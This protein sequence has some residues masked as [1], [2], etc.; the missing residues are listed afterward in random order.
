MSR[1][2]G[3][4]VATRELAVRIFLDTSQV[5]GASERASG[6]FTGIGA[7]A[8]RAAVAAQAAM[9]RMA[10][11][12]EGMAGKVTAS[13]EKAAA[14]QIAAAERASLAGVAGQER[15]AAAAAEGSAATTA[16]ADRS[17]ASRIGAAD[18]AAAAEIAAAER[19]AAAQVRAAEQAAAAQ[20]ASRA[21]VE[22]QALTGF[23][24]GTSM[25][26]LGV[27]VAGFAGLASILSQTKEYETT[28]SILRQN[29]QASDA[30]M[31]ALDATALRLGND[32]TIPGA[33][34]ADAARAMTEL[35]K[36][37]LTVEQAMAAAKGTLQL[38]TAA[39][40]DGA[41][42]ADIETSALG[43]FQLR[44]GDAAHVADVLANTAVAAKG[45]ITD[46][47]YGME[48]AGTVAHQFGMSIDDTSTVL[49]LFAKNG[50]IGEQ[51]GT[52]LRTMLVKMAHPTLAA[53]NAMKDLGITVYDAQGKFEGMRAL[54]EQLAAAHSKM[55]LEEFNA[56][57]ATIFGTRAIRG[58][59]IAAAEG[60]AGW[61]SM[62]KKISE[63][64]GVA[65]MAEAHMAG[66][67]GGL[68]DVG[69]SLENMAIK[70][71]QK[72]TPAL[73]AMAHGFAEGM[74]V[75]SAVFTVMASAVGGFLTVL[76]SLPAPVWAAV[77]ALTAIKIL[78]GP[79]LSMFSM[80]APRIAALRETMAAIRMAPL[81]DG[82][83][84]LR[85]GMGVAASAAGNLGRNML[86]LVGGPIGAA[87]IM[88]AAGT[89]IASKAMDQAA[90]STADFTAAI[91]DQTGAL[92]SNAQAMAAKTLA[93]SGS[94]QKAKDM[95]ISADVYTKAV[96]GN[97]DAIAQ[98]NDA[99][100]RG[101]TGQSEFQQ[102]MDAANQSVDGGVIA[103]SK[104]QGQWD[105]AS[106][107]ANQFAA[108]TGQL[109]AQV[110]A[111][112][113]ALQGAGNTTVTT[114]ASMSDLSA[115]L[116]DAAVSADDVASAMTAQS[117]AT[118]AAKEST[119]YLTISMQLMAGK[120]V[121]AEAAARANAAAMRGI[122][123]AA[124]DQVSAN[125]AAQDA[126]K[127]L[128][129]V[130][131]HLHDS[132]EK[133]RTSVDDVTRAQ[134]ALDDANAKVSAG[135]E[136]Q[137]S[138]W[139]QAAQTA[140]TMTDVVYRQARAHM[141]QKDAVAAATDQMAKQRAEFIKN[142]IN[143]GMEAGAAV[144]LAD[145]LGLIPANVTTAYEAKGLAAAMADYDRVLALIKQINDTQITD[146][147]FKITATVVQQGTLQG[148]IHI[149]SPSG[150][151]GTITKADGGIVEAGM[152]HAAN[153]L[154]RQPMI[155]KGGSNILWAEPETGWEAYI[156]GKPGQE[157]ANR[158]ILGIAASRLGMSSVMGSDGAAAPV[159]GSNTYSTQTS[160]H[161]VYNSTPAQSGGSAA[162]APVNLQVMIGDRDITDIVDVRIAQT[163][164][165]GAKLV[166]AQKQLDRS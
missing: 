49:G 118:K 53:S 126:A 74:P 143:A 21:R 105:Q 81:I 154:L 23:G 66:L 112:K 75:I 108:D 156:S 71:G 110:D 86:A 61:D 77:A 141:S 115:G 73:T 111:T 166:A 98:V 42:A 68:L 136:N 70:V 109:G 159:V 60:T 102:Q 160:T 131:S 57:T 91:D 89:V 12:A 36:G 4:W 94:L 15:Q 34:A 157:A 97:A 83:S 92:K 101:L 145:K 134:I 121:D 132:N 72:L 1:S 93:D 24:M 64:A 40:V 129:D 137:Q 50:V 43:A 84:S 59:A 76:S 10:V 103:V 79:L 7:A 104:L 35:A 162:A 78:D 22:K 44:A 48:S 150:G 139:D 151:S 25:V 41:R 147:N 11:A 30:Q 20:A 142:A 152:T 67:R 51:A 146:K 100:G 63:G 47:A 140:F 26:T 148:G 37:G 138:A 155:A 107:F 164:I 153:G 161:N 2:R 124:R 113:A 116:G 18:R 56:A 125:L 120:D 19:A 5:A 29:T 17:A 123:Q 85:V 122:G 54:T 82:I 33:S 55:S 80:L 128:A 95:G 130:Q 46:F 3:C 117:D 69:N 99:I 114:T 135:V 65:A 28:M 58:A 96:L 32:L 87:L 149:S 106:L 90:T 52:T 119:D 9:E 27:G 144:N 38:A 88:A 127:K 14:A 163:P 8:E 13:A 165:P 31:Q 6:S 16:A 62:S 158:K 133:T 45:D 39:E